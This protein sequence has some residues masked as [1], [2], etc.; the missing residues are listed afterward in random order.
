MF[1]LKVSTV[2]QNVN[3]MDKSF[4]KG[5]SICAIFSE[6]T[7]LKL[8]ENISL[9]YPLL[10]SYYGATKP[11]KW[12]MWARYLV[13][14]MLQGS[15]RGSCL[16]NS[17]ILAAKNLGPLQEGLAI[18]PKI[19]FMTILDMDPTRKADYSSESER[20]VPHSLCKAV[21]YNMNHISNMNDWFYQI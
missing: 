21:K 9:S 19:Y 5:D 11:L 15:L 8:L 7:H 18:C 17:C 16:P 2:L 14:T 4:G 3:W 1:L 6:S 12:S 10:C 20:R 13:S